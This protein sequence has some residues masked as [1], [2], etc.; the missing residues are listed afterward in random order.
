MN[1]VTGRMGKNQHLLR[2][3]VEIIK[4]GGVRISDDECIMPDPILVGRNDSKLKALSELS[5]IGKYTT[6]LDE[7]I[8]DPAYSVYFDAQTTGRR[9]GAVRL[10]ASNGKHVYCEKPTASDFKTAYDLYEFCENA[11]VCYKPS[12][13]G[14]GDLDLSPLVTHTFPLEDWEKAFHTYASGEG[15]KVVFTPNPHTC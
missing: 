8:K 10:A 2:S 5:G 3:I 15:L 6:N 4:Q 11:G 1:G 7:V 13:A 12:G 14:G 9:A